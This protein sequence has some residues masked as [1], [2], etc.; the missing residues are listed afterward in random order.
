MTPHDQNRNDEFAL[1]L[2]LYQ[3]QT[4]QHPQNTAKDNTIYAPHTGALIHANND[5]DAV[6]AWLAQYLPSPNTFNSYRKEAERLLLWMQYQ[7]ISC[8]A[9]LKQDDFLL[10][11]N[12]LAAPHPAEQWIMPRGRRLSRRHPQWRPFAGPL[13]KSSIQQS[14]TI[15]NSLMQWLVA[16]RYLNANPLSLLRQPWGQQTSTQGTVKR[17]IP[18]HLWQQILITI[19]QLPRDTSRKKDEYHRFRWLFSLFYATGLRVSELC[20]HTMGDF[21]NDFDAAG[22]PQWWLYITGKGERQRTVPVTAELMRELA[23]YRMSLGLP[24]TPQPHEPYP[25]VM[26]LND[27]GIHPEAPPQHASLGATESPQNGV[28]PAQLRPLTRATIHRLVKTLCRRT[29]DRLRQI[30]PEH[31]SDAQLLTRVSPHWLRHTAG[32]HM[33]ENDIDILH[34][35]DTLGH[36]SLQTTNRYL[37]TAERERH[38]HTEQKHSIG[39]PMDQAQI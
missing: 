12:F 34:V 27:G 9:Q 38:R 2:P 30:G 14:L 23:V 32:T 39:W 19:D 16:A 7:G 28:N 13:S 20:T 8:L 21:R 11:R 37:H 36:R 5:L 18:Q 26:A 22:R 24:S 1:T 25:L 15:L 29:A 6:R 17:Y 4:T 10:Y 33:V 35:R 31:E 3:V